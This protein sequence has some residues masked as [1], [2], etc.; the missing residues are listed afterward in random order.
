MFDLARE[1]GGYCVFTSGSHVHGVHGAYS[2]PRFAYDRVVVQRDLP[3]SARK[4]Y[5]YLFPFRRLLNVRSV[6]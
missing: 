3:Q 4:V 2:F 1:P 6:G 5:R